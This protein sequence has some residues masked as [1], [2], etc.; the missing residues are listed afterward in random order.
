MTLILLNVLY[1]RHPI[2]SS[3]VPFKNCGGQ[4]LSRSNGAVFDVYIVWPETVTKR[5]RCENSI[6]LDLLLD[7]L[8]KSRSVLV[9]DFTK[10]AN[11]LICFVLSFRNIFTLILNTVLTKLLTARILMVTPLLRKLNHFKVVICWVKLNSPP[12][13]DKP[14]LM[15]TPLIN[16]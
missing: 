15:Q 14:K 2:V 13:F 9:L 8:Y 6:I 12:G 7:Y 10:T 16:E 1:Y 11:I 5:G 3:N 4:S